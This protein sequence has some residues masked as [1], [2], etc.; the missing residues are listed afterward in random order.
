MSAGSST[1][2]PDESVKETG[3]PVG[4]WVG[5]PLAVG[6]G[7]AVGVGCWAWAAPVKEATAT[8][9]ELAS[10]VTTLKAE[11]AR[12]GRDWEEELQQRG[13]ELA[14]MRDLGLTQQQA[15][16]ATMPVDDAPEEAKAA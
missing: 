14:L 15:A 3:P 11:Y 6:D 13:R 1:T 9:I 16:P 8:Q 5:A 12:Q 7:A 10:H 2:R 4:V